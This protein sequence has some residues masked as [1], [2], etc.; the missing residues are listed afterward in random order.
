M[1]QCPPRD[2]AYGATGRLVDRR[3]FKE[4]MEIYD[5]SSMLNQVR[6]RR[7]LLFAFLL[8]PCLS[9]LLCSALLVASKF[10]LPAAR[11]SILFYSYA[12]EKRRK[13]QATGFPKSSQRCQ[14]NPNLGG[15]LKG[16]EIVCPS[17][18]LPCNLQYTAMKYRPLHQ[19]P[20]F[21]AYRNCNRRSLI[22]CRRHYSVASRFSFVYIKRC[23]KCWPVK[24]E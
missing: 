24:H 13:S 1:K 11:S 23:Q 10:L 16:G 19:Y 5:F 3:G 20:S 2:R 7:C 4:A 12:S 18:V 17:H 6:R 15:R 22:E 14:T 21:V 9:W 8:W